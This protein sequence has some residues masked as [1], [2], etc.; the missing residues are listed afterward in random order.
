MAI[1]WKTESDVIRPDLGQRVGAL[2]PERVGG[3]SSGPGG[4]PE[5]IMGLNVGVHVSDNASCVRMN[6]SLVAQMTPGEPRW[7]TQVHGTDVV[8]AETVERD[9]V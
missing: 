9:E 5:G 7:M 4:G 1:A 8:D 6:R 3:V 2:F